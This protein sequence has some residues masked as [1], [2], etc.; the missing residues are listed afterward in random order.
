MFIFDTRV[1]NDSTSYQTRK[2]GILRAQFTID[3]VK[4]LR[5]NLEKVKAN[6][7]VFHDKTEDVMKDLCDYKTVVVHMGE[8]GPA[9]IR[10]E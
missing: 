2:T 4:V 7:L 3:S 8:S 6:L 5:K 9:D 1:F 10:M